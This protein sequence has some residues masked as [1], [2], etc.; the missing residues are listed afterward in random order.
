MY[1][2]MPCN[3]EVAVQLTGWHPEL[4]VL[5]HAHANWSLDY[6][7]HALLVSLLHNSDHARVTTKV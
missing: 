1:R 6:T 2:K 5:S 3:R 4:S 7:D